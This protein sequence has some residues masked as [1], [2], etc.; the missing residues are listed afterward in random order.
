MPFPHAFLIW[1]WKTSLFFLI[2]SFCIKIK[3]TFVKEFQDVHR[4]HLFTLPFII[5][6]CLTMHSFQYCLTCCLYFKA[7]HANCTTEELGN[8]DSKVVNFKLKKILGGDASERPFSHAGVMKWFR[9][10]LWPLPSSSISLCHNTLAWS[11]ENGLF[12]C[13]VPYGILFANSECGQRVY[14][15]S[16]EHLNS[17]DIFY[18]CD[19]FCDTI[20]TQWMV[21]FRRTNSLQRKGML[22]VRVTVKIHFKGLEGQLKMM[23]AMIIAMLPTV[24]FFIV[25][26]D[27]LYLIWFSQKHIEAISEGLLYQL[28][29]C[30]NW[31]AKRLNG[32]RANSQVLWLPLT[33][34]LNY[35]L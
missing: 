21:Q 26:M 15:K 30:G 5:V 22:A 3:Y 7:C 8:D 33:P 34:L 25:Y 12:M 9:S 18:D 35:S 23:M 14:R 19:I 29:R 16:Q 4:H 20:S 13:I 6:P 32:V 2:S 1:N 28:S 27:L 17:L 10:V 31:G 11:T 24:G